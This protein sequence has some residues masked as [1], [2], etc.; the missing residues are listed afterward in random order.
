MTIIVNKIDAQ[1]A[2]L[3]QRA[4]VG[5]AATNGPLAGHGQFKPTVFTRTLQASRTG[6]FLV[7]IGTGQLDP[8]NHARIMR[9]LAVDEQ[10]DINVLVDQY[11]ETLHQ[12]AF[13]SEIIRSTVAA[14]LGNNDRHTNMASVAKVPAAF[15]IK[16]LVNKLHGKG[17]SRTD[18]IIVHLHADA[19][20]TI[21]AQLN[22]IS[23][24]APHVHRMRP[25]SL[26]PN[27]TDLLDVMK[28]RDVM[29]MATQLANADVSL[30]M[31]SVKNGRAG[32]A[33]S[34]SIISQHIQNAFV[35]A[36]DASKGSYA[37][38]D[39]VDSVLN[40]LMRVWSPMTN[41]TRMPSERV[42]KS[43]FVAEFQSNLGLFLAAQDMASHPSSSSEIAFGDEELTSTILPLFQET[44]N[45]VSPYKVM[46]LT[47]AIGFYGMKSSRDH[48]SEP[49]NIFLFEDWK[50]QDRVDA[51][52]PI[53]Q[54]LNSSG[55]FLQDMAGVSSA[56][57]NTLSPV[58]KVVSL[59]D[60]IEIR[61]DSY[62][63]DEL[64][65]RAS[66]PTQIHMAFPSL[67][68]REAQLEVKQFGA[69]SPFIIEGKDP[70]SD[71]LTKLGVTVRQIESLRF[72]YYAS[73]MHLAIAKGQSL[74]VGELQSETDAESGITLN[75]LYIKWTQKTSFTR[76]RGLSALL[77]GQVE[78]TEPLE[79]IA[80]MADFDPSDSLTVNYPYLS[81]H[82]GAL[83]LWN[84]PRY[85][86]TL[87]LDAS[88]DIT[89]RNKK[90]TVNVN[91]HEMLA[92]GA[93]RNEIRFM[94]QYDTKALVN[95]F[96]KHVSD[97][98]TFIK[99]MAK[100]AKDPLVRDAYRGREI[101]SALRLVGML[102]G[103]ASNGAGQRA[104]AYAKQR[105]AD[106]MYGM[107][108]TL[109]G[110]DEIHVGVQNH[111]LRVWAGIRVLELLQLI[112]A[113]EAAKIANMVRESNA[114][115]YALST[116]DLA[117]FK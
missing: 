100:N 21:L 59:K 105:V 10:K 107:T 12:L 36:Y 44:I 76:Q 92:L 97:D 24:D 77:H 8:V 63:M 34:T 50:V 80:Y 74:S 42:L 69:L 41:E 65:K 6:E 15:V 11:R 31:K 57:A 114:L 87:A 78:T 90:Y 17:V 112:T 79:V 85:S 101:Q 18:E 94:N 1:A 103:V 48:N 4:H 86:S 72:D 89:L 81:D 13:D 20:I 47:D 61:V 83:H 91:E 70:S 104:I 96:F 54:S 14:I 16:H 66:Q 27:Y 5:G 35:G 39:V 2:G 53:R 106:K 3:T 28:L 75:P 71:D 108:G 109:D 23:E 43:P 99:T 84:W 95:L 7:P 49:G 9:Q 115:A 116:V 38:N 52:V 40:L 37:A 67:E 102:S 60:S 117:T 98:F 30:L 110:Y 93:R 32:G 19:L 113:E 45:L 111:R 26:F 25:G 68:V 22:L 82:D 46:A 88:F 29:F 62:N 56:L 33:L 58:Q 73:I 64:T 51:F 55:R